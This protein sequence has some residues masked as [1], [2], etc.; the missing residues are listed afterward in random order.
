MNLTVSKSYVSGTNRLLCQ[1]HKVT[2][3]RDQFSISDR[4][5]ATKYRSAAGRKVCTIAQHLTHITKSPSGRRAITLTTENPALPLGGT[6]Y[7][8][9]CRRTIPRS[10]SM[11]RYAQ[12]CPLDS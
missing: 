3:R 11:Y 10:I 8:E 1:P 12:A 5:A 4:M 9:E 7:S 2:S 6:A